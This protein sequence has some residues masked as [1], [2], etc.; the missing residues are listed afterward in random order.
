VIVSGV[1][2]SVALFYILYLW[3]AQNHAEQAESEFR[4]DALRHVAAIRSSLK[5]HMKV[6]Y[7]LTVFYKHASHITREEFHIFAG[8]LAQTSPSMQAL[9]W[10]PK[11]TAAERKEYEEKGRK[12][13]SGFRF[14]E[15]GKNGQLITAASRDDYYPVYFIEP[16][17]GNEVAAGFDMASETTRRNT[18]PGVTAINTGNTAAKSG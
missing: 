11:V 5:I 12:A 13:I 3:Q 4:Q 6:A 17:I 15:L 18:C 9:E 10:I 14:T 8:S 1:L 7:T 2:I 16:Y